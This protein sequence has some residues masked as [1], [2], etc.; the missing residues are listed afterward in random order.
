MD[1]CK[2]PP[3]LLDP[4]ILVGAGQIARPTMGSISGEERQRKN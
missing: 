2:G 3:Q 1:R 4:L